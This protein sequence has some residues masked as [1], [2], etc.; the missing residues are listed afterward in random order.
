MQRSVIG[1][2]TIGV[3]LWGCGPAREPARLGPLPEPALETRAAAR[4]VAPRSRPPVVEPPPR[5]EPRP[6]PIPG[7]WL[8]AGG[9][10]PG[11][12]RAVVVHHSASRQATP[13]GMHRYHLLQRGWENG[14]G[15][16]F[17]IGNGVNYP[18]GEVYVGHR[19]NGQQT[20][21]HCK[22][23]AGRYFGTW[24]PDNFFNERAVG[25]C[26]IGNFEQEAPTRAQL[27]SLTRLL[28]FLCREAGINPDCI[29]GHGEVTHK[30]A[31]PGRQLN[32]NAVRRAVRQA[33]ASSSL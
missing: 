22:A 28:A 24:R 4:P 27:D 11:R 15:Y 32:M 3:A 31:C 20:G 12:W 23:G 18:N 5:V 30:T 8:P 10:E 19:W 16:H 33:L 9:I 6:T 14:L 17:V 26:L 21:A 2:L 25:I 1:V 7:G 29:Y 13:Q